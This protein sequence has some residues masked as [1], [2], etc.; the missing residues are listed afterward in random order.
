[1][2]RA[3][4]SLLDGLLGEEMLPLLAEELR[5]ATLR[6]LEW[7]HE[8]RLHPIM[9]ALMDRHRDLLARKET[10][11]WRSR[12]RALAEERRGSGPVGEAMMRVSMMGTITVVGQEGEARALRGARARTMLGLLVA[13]E[14][15]RV[16]LTRREFTTIASGGEEDAELAKKT[17]VM[18]A[19][20]L[21]EMIGAETVIT[22][23]P[24]YRI[25]LTQVSVDLLEAHARVEEARR[26]LRR[27][28]LPTATA[29]MLAALRIARGEVPF[30]GLYDNFFETVRDDFESRLRGT[31]IDLAQILL[32]ESQ[33]EMAEELLK[34]AFD[35][36]R[37]DE[38]IAELLEE[39]LAATGHRTDSLRVGRMVQ[40]S[41]D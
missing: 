37:D 3:A 38:E 26:A 6:A 20:R 10:T 4:I 23:E 29:A 35:R 34:G 28:A 24:M 36:M 25:D 33:A 21:R 27:G 5:L 1:M 32:R 14:M 39:A 12:I 41:I 7:L 8:R 22:G 13:A 9:T 11:A 16:P 15:V 18:A 19:A 17:T 40:D 31:V 30:P 2:L